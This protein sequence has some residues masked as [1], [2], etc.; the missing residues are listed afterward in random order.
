[1]VLADDPAHPDSDTFSRIHARVRGTGHWNEE[2]GRNLAAALYRAQAEDPLVQR[3]DAVMGGRGRDGAENVF[4]VYMPHGEKGPSFFAQVD[5][6]VA[7][8]QPAE[9]SL[10]QAERLWTQRVQEVRQHERAI[11]PRVTV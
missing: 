1:M 9:R 6:R 8:Q 4:A 2:Q 11:A 3:V 7:A 5:G 10:A